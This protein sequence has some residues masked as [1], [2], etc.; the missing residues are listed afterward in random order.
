MKFCFSSSYANQYLNY[1]KPAVFL[2]KG[3]NNAKHV[4]DEIPFEGNTNYN[5]EYK[6]YQGSNFDKS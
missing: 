6:E 3:N 4:V 1:G 2:A 5:L